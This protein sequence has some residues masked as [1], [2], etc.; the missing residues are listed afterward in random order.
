MPIV[1]GLNRTWR[2]ICQEEFFYKR[3]FFR[4][5][6]HLFSAFFPQRFLGCRVDPLVVELSESVI[7]TVVFANE[8][9]TNSESSAQNHYDTKVS[10]ENDEF[11]EFSLLFRHRNLTLI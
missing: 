6:F 11:L 7:V 1:T 8:I 10:D 9:A 4:H 5:L 2:H 3:L